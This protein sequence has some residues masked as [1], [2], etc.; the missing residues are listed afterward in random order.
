MAMLPDTM[1]AVVAKG[2]GG[3]DVL[4]IVTRPV[5]RPGHGEVLVRGAAVFRGYW[6]N[7][8]ATAEVFDDDGWFKT[9]DVGR[10]DDDGYLYI[11]DRKKDLIVTSAGKNVAPAVLEDRLRAHWLVSQALVVGDARPYVAALLTLDQESLGLWRTDLGKPDDAPLDDPDL[12]RAVQEAVDH[13][14]AA[15]S[16][17]EAIKR[18]RLLPEDFTLAAGEVTPTLKLRRAVVAAEHQAEVEELYR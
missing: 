3:P 14:N 18:W 8:D 11:T 10:L 13:A 1:R 7:E 15:V 6:Q 12:V 9:G 2:A 5:P 4:E 16:Q 17:A